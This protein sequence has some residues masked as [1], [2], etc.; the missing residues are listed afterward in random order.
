[1]TRPRHDRE[2]RNRQTNSLIGYRKFNGGTPSLLPLTQFSTHLRQSCEPDLFS[3]VLEHTQSKNQKNRF[4]PKVPFQTNGFPAFK[5]KQPPKLKKPKT[6]AFSNAVRN[7]SSQPGWLVSVLLSSRPGFPATHCAPPLALLQGQ[8]RLLLQAV[9]GYNQL[10]VVGTPER[11]RGHQARLY[12]RIFTQFW[13]TMGIRGS[14]NLMSRR[15]STTAATTRTAAGVRTDIN[16][17]GENL[18]GLCQFLHRQLRS[19]HQRSFDVQDTL[20][21]RSLPKV[22]LHRTRSSHF[23]PFV[24]V[25]APVMGRPCPTLEWVRMS[26]GSISDRHTTT[27]STAYPTPCEPCICPFIPDSKPRHEGG[28]ERRVQEYSDRLGFC[29]LSSEWHAPAEVVPMSTAASGPSGCK[30]PNNLTHPPSNLRRFS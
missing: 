5:Q 16:A 11:S 26:I 6:T 24:W 1:L 13:A 14:C 8:R 10:N 12:G 15:L 9:R 20:T 29:S 27:S 30:I 7:K 22:A 21:S 3:S 25:F 2:K 28:V 23:H 18:V 17:A 4:H 19:L